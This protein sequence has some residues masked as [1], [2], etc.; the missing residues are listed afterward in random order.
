MIIRNG[1]VFQEDGTYLVQ[2]VY[3][4]NGRIAASEEEVTDKTVVDASGLK[5][6]PGMVDV[7]S[8]GAK[9][10]DFSDADAEGLRAI[11][12]YE[13]SSGV[14]TWCPTSMTLPKEQLLKIFRTA[15]EVET[16]ETCAHI[17]GINM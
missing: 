14:T 8:H 17:G 10:H 5:V 7:H 1:R 3:V 16:D 12:Q 2:D 9:G 4:E 13:K 6:L 15:V 11:L